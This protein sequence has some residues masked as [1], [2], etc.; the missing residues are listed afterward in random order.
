M[1]TF[2]RSLARRLELNRG[3]SVVL[4][5]DASMRRYQRKFA[6]KDEPTDVLSFPNPAEKWEVEPYAGDILI[7][8]E[9]AE[10]QRQGSLEQE[11][12]I[13][14]LHGLLHLLGYDHESDD[15]Q[16]ERLERKLRNELELP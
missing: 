12:K 2:V 16:M 11:L 9:T 15:G 1:R 4:L 10:R 13:L 14:S 7:S 8:V 6:G 3:W 5:S